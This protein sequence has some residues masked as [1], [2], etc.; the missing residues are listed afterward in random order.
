MDFQ[1]LLADDDEDDCMFFREALEELSLCATLKTVNNGVELMNFLENNLLNLPQMLF[2]DLNMPRKSGA[3]CL[4]EIKQNVKFKHL[5]V[6]IYSTSSNID[7]MDQLY[8][9]GAHYYIRKP[10]DFSNLKS[11]IR[12]T[13]DLILQKDVLPS[14]REEFVIQP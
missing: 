11:V 7:V 10:A 12:R 2:L 4:S 1:I 5:P 8:G 3:E 9:E 13:I 6:I 14:T